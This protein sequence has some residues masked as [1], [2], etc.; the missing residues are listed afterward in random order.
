MSSFDEHILT[1]VIIKGY[2][3]GFLKLF[4]VF[5]KQRFFKDFLNCGY[6]SIIFNKYT[7]LRSSF[8]NKSSREQIEKRV[9]TKKINLLFYEFTFKVFY[10]NLNSLNFKGISLK[11]SKHYFLYNANFQ[12]N[13]KSLIKNNYK[14]NFIYLW[15]FTNSKKQIVF[16]KAI[17]KS[18]KKGIHKVLPII[19]QSRRFSKFLIT[20]FLNTR[21]FLDSYYS[22]LPVY[23][24][25]ENVPRVLSEKYT[26]K[27]QVPLQK[28]FGED[29]EKKT[30]K[31]FPKQEIKRRFHHD[32]MMKQKRK[33]KNRPVIGYS[34][35]SPAFLVKD[36]FFILKRS[37]LLLFYSYSFNN[38]FKLKNPTRRHLLQLNVFSIK[39]KVKL[40]RGRHLLYSI[41]RYRKFFIW[42]CL[43]SFPYGGGYSGLV[44]KISID[45]FNVFLKINLGLK[46]GPFNFKSNVFFNKTLKFLVKKKKSF[47]KFLSLIKV[48]GLNKLVHFLSKKSLI[49]FRRFKYSKYVTIKKFRKKANNFKSMDPWL[50]NK[51]LTKKYRLNEM[52]FYH[53]LKKFENMKEIRFF[54]SVRFFEK[55]KDFRHLF[56]WS[57]QEHAKKRFRQ[58]DFN[59]KKGFWVSKKWGVRYEKTRIVYGVSPTVFDNAQKKNFQRKR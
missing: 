47:Y 7:L 59:K 6:N 36:S 40:I 15:V 11:L 57:K 12:N 16:K 35:K 46:T 28:Q 5:L 33:L 24:P 52:G 23:A 9:Y 32:F 39:E 49:T 45:K 31:K 2:T 58:K 3:E 13:I 1:V 56:F 20:K 44:E 30:G 27:Q 17:N 51:Y 42:S 14:S 8:I 19:G 41:L 18:L 38:I 37:S 54:N 48:I 34:Y 43:T 53:V 10:S 29:L 25:K 55:N 50:I 26:R 21:S 22:K 4:L